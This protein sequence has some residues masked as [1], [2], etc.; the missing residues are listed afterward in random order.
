VNKI[1]PG[2]PNYL[3]TAR[4]DGKDKVLSPGYI[5]KAVRVGKQFLTWL[6]VHKRGYG[7]LSQ[8]WLSTLTPPR[9]VIEP[10]EHQ[11]VTLEEVRAIAGAPTYTLRERRI[12]AAAVFWF[13]SGI[14]IGAFVTLPIKAIKLNDMSL[15]QWPSLGVRTKF[16]KHATTYL[17]DIPDLL[18]VVKEWDNEV[19]SILTSDSL[20]FAHISTETEKL[21]PDKS[22]AGKHRHARARKSLK[23][24]LSK[25]GLPYHKPHSFMHG[26]AVYSIQMAKDLS[27]LKAISM[28]L[29]HENLQVT[30][31]VYGIFSNLDLHKII[32]GLGKTSSQTNM[33]KQELILILE[34]TLIN[35]QRSGK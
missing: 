9:M 3:I 21:E 18:E 5:K 15:K 10:K 1:R 35:L 25:I 2:F 22:K 4:L 34:Q 30:D 23:A 8:A 20:R 11:A 19:R 33:N 27:A 31:G 14:R 12:K 16:N 6:K 13:L 32:T 24:W 26:H 29:M 7:N 28:N 17:L